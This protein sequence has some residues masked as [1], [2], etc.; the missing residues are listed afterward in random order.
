MAEDSG[1][2]AAIPPVVG[3]LRDA[4]AVVWRFMRFLLGA[5]RIEPSK[6]ESFLL[7]EVAFQ[8]ASVQAHCA[9]PVET[10]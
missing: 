8:V 4:I 2:I 9:F 3:V 6:S 10:C 1:M 7:A 5:E